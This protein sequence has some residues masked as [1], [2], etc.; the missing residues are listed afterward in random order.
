[1]KN[2]LFP[3][4]I[5]IFL[6]SFLIY[7][8]LSNTNLTSNKENDNTLNISNYTLNTILS[9]NNEFIENDISIKL[10]SIQK[11]FDSS[12][13]QEGV[14]E[15][16]NSSLSS[17]IEFNSSSESSLTKIDYDFIIYDDNYLIYN[18]SFDYNN[19]DFQSTIQLLNDYNNL[20][21][22]T[23]KLENSINFISNNYT[24]VLDYSTNTFTE[25]LF[26]NLTSD[27]AFT[28]L[29]ILIFNLSYMLDDSE[30]VFKIDYPL[31]FD[32]NLI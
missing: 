10:I 23:T 14:E 18:Y 7:T 15:S 24:S 16:L 28:N 22:D 17:I 4:L 25:T 11:Q 31:T 2:K 26:S 32:I 20:N 30:D 8:F 6:S 12:I 13:F 5:I 19:G 21:F 1:M 29:N 9:S 27:L 3:I